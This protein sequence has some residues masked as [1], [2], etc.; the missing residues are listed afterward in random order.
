LGSPVSFYNL[1]IAFLANTLEV[2]TDIN[3]HQFI[4]GIYP[5]QSKDYMQI[6]QHGTHHYGRMESYGF[7]MHVDHHDTPEN[8]KQK[9]GKFP[10][11]IKNSVRLDEQLTDFE[12]DNPTHRILVALFDKYQN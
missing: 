2:T 7:A 4:P 12:W 9:Y 11:E 3:G 5:K 8:L 1:I 10:D 6:T